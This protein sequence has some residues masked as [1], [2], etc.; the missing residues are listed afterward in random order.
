M[1]PITFD[2]HFFRKNSKHNKPQIKNLKY[3]CK[4]FEHVLQTYL[5]WVVALRKRKEFLQVNVKYK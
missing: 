2:A 1:I 5:I 4:K 3:F